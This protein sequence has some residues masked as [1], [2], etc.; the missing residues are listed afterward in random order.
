[1]KRRIHIRALIIL[2]LCIVSV[3]SYAQT[4]IDSLPNDPGKLVV[5]TMQNLKFGAFSQ[6]ALGGTVTISPSGTRTSTGDVIL[7]NMG[8]TYYQ[9]LFDLEVPYGTV[10][11]LMNGPN[12]TLVGSNGGSMSMAIGDSSPSSPFFTSVQPPGRTQLSL[13]GTLTVGNP[14][15]NPPGTYSGTLF[16]TFNQE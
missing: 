2:I 7:L 6:G 13:G 15:S 12:V 10:V 16:I 4:P 8:I 3:T 1:M 5:Y 9:A 14:V 11:S